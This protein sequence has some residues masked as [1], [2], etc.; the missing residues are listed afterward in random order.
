MLC[1]ASQKLP[2]THS[3]YKINRS[4]EKSQSVRDRARLISEAC[5]KYDITRPEYEERFA[6]WCYMRALYRDQKY[7]D[8]RRHDL[9]ALRLAVKERAADRISRKA[10]TESQAII[11]SVGDRAVANDTTLQAAFPST[12]LISSQT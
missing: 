12:A 8:K 1:Y 11:A 5:Q 7:M 6:A 3:P 9:D 4:R 10:A 2:W